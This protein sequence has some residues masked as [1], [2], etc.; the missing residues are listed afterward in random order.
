MLQPYHQLRWKLGFLFWLE[1]LWLIYF[2]EIGLHYNWS[3]GFT[4]ITFVCIKVF[5]K[6]L[7]F[8]F[9]HWVIGLIPCIFK[10]FTNQGVICRCSFRFTKSLFCISRIRSLAIQGERLFFTVF[11]LMN[12][13][14][15]SVT[16]ANGCFQKSH[17]SF[18]L[19]YNVTRFQSIIRRS[20]KNSAWLKFLSCQTSTVLCI[21]ERRWVTLRVR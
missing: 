17:T 18:V 19:I 5:R 20:R 15:L 9:L 7:T 11:V 10:L 2:A 8:S 13:A 12:D 16:F 6:A 3:P 21:S 1:T 14:C 4:R